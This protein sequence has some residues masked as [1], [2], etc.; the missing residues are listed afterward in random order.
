MAREK[1]PRQIELGEWWSEWKDWTITPTSLISPEG[2]LW[3]AAKLNATFFQLQQLREY[4]NMLRS[5]EQYDLFDK[6]SYLF[7]E[8]NPPR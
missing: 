1:T 7:D 8:P 3:D 2:V 4:R 5:P 6:P